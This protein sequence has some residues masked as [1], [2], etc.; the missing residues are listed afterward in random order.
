[1]EFGLFCLNKMIER[2]FEVEKLMEFDPQ[3]TTHKDDNA[4]HNDTQRHNI[5]IHCDEMCPINV[6]R[7]NLFSLQFDKLFCV[8]FFR[9]SFLP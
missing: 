6:Q 8:L 4:S 7:F 3:T 2:G 1:M 5:M 9:H